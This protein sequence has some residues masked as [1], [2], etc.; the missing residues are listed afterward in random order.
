MQLRRLT[1]YSTIE[2]EKEAEELSTTIASLRLIL[3]D[4]SG[5]CTAS[6]ATS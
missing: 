6:S 2:L 3:D 5:C 4:E 1:R